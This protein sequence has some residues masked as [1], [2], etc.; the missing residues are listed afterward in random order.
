MLTSRL[1]LHEE[2]RTILLYLEEIQLGSHLNIES[3]QTSLRKSYRLFGDLSQNMT[4][5]DQASVKG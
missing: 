1:L 3:L 4:A 2:Y 5:V